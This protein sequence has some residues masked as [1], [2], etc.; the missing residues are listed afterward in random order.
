ML[1]ALR[2]PIAKL[3][4]KEIETAKE[5]V[6]CLK[7]ELEQLPDLF[8][9]KKILKNEFEK[10]FNITLIKEDLTKKEK[11]IFK[12]KKKKFSTNKYINKIQLPKDKQHMIYSIYKADGGLIRLSLMV[13]LNF[14]RFQSVVITGDFFVYPKRFILDL[15][16]SLKDVPI[17]IHTINER[18]SGVFDEKKP[19][20]P[21]ISV[22]DFTSAF[23]KAMEK[24]DIAKTGISLAHSNRIYTVNSSFQEIIKL[25]PRH[26]LLPYCAKSTDCGFRYKRECA[27]CGQ[28]SISDA[29][30]IGRENK[31][32]ITTIMNFED[33]MET[34]QNFSS[35]NVKSYVGCC[36]EAFYTKHL[37]DFSKSGVP[38]ILIDIDNTTCYDLDMEQLAYKGDFESQTDI[39][40]DILEKVL[41]VCI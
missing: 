25:K 18:I 38:G 26:L 32:D 33:L 31:M 7:W 11:E 29:F 23:Q 10:T 28:C 17:D 40:L 9:L 22:D 6:T 5:R 19:E 34:L 15:E 21:G 24:I 27:E 13:N 30:Q 8:S 14:N 12:V 35:K 39:N 20:I 16:A 3:K 4:D 36:C 37:E 2:I 41:D 1:K